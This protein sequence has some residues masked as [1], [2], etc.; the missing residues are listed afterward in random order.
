MALIEGVESAR[1]VPPAVGHNHHCIF[2]L[3]VDAYASYCPLQS[4]ALSF[5]CLVCKQLVERKGAVTEAVFAKQLQIAAIPAL[6][7]M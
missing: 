6:Q 1:L 4:C 3:P 5:R 2:G 7:A